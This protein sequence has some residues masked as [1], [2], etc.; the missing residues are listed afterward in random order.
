MTCRLDADQGTIGEAAV[1]MSNVKTRSFKVDSSSWERFPSRV[2]A[3]DPAMKERYIRRMQAEL[4]K[5]REYFSIGAAYCDNM[6]VAERMG[7]GVYARK[8]TY[9]IDFAGCFNLVLSKMTGV[10][11]ELLNSLLPDS[12]FNEYYRVLRSQSRAD[13]S[14]IM[15]LT[16]ECVEYFAELVRG[17]PQEVEDLVMERFLE[18]LQKIMGYVFIDYQQ[19]LQKEQNIGIIL[20]SYTFCE[21]II[22]TDTPLNGDIDIAFNGGMARA[23]V[24]LQPEE[25]VVL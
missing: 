2:I 4:Q 11:L 22:T 21:L 24:K 23:K 10:S 7:L 20:R 6:A 1:K 13:F 18:T 17:A 25:I 8:Y 5:K 15:R 3:M 9:T 19:Q 16:P 12:T 14:K